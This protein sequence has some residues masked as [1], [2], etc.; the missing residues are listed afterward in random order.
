MCIRDRLNIFDLIFFSH[1]SYLSNSKN[2][3]FLPHLGGHRAKE[4]RYSSRL[5]SV[6]RHKKVG[7][8]GAVGNF[9]KEK[10]GVGRGK[11]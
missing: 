7:R 9:L 2:F 3:V 10:T 11:L 1:C 8:W 4:N 5:M 6:R